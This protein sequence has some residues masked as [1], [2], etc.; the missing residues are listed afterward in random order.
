MAIRYMNAPGE[1][2]A[3]IDAEGYFHSGDLGQLENGRLSLTGRQSSFVN[4]GGRKLDPIEITER[5]LRIPRVAD[6]IA[7]QD[8]DGNGEGLLHLVVVPKGDLTRA[9]LLSD[10]RQDLATW[11]LPARITFAPEIPRNGIGKPIL[12]HFM[13][14]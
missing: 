10:F 12:S 9:E 7:F 3:R 14:T 5:A 4:V 11:K 8:K 13:K 2:E 1:L 6:A